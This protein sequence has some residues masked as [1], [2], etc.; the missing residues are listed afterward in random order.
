MK[1]DILK[2]I[3]MMPASEAKQN[4]KKRNKGEPQ[5]RHD[6]R[7]KSSLLRKDYNTE[8]TRV[9]GLRLTNT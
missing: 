6:A 5:N 1:N 9:T 3:L 7:R 8:L 2:I 4:Q